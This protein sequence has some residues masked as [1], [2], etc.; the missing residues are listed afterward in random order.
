MTTETDFQV[1][2]DEF[3]FPMVEDVVNNLPQRIREENSELLTSEVE[4]VLEDVSFDTL[5]RSSS[6]PKGS[7]TF[8]RY[9]F[10]RPEI[11]T[12][13]VVG[14]YESETMDLENTEIKV[15]PSEIDGV[16][17]FEV[18]PNGHVSVE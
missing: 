1:F 14:F 12:V 18:Q 11:V 6:Y 3:S 16:I 13:R 7:T 9:L 5:E 2:K 17:T 10:E 8:V 15:T 4:S